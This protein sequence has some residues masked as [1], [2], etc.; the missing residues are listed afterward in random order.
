MK[1]KLNQKATLVLKPKRD[2]ALRNRH[3]WV[4]SGAVKDAP[5]AA[6]GDIV[7]VVS[8]EG[9]RLGYGH[10]MIGRD[11]CCRMLLFTHEAAQINE[12]FWRERFERALHHRRTFL[13]PEETS[14]YRLINAEGDSLPG[15]IVDV[16][17]D[18]AVIQARTE[19]MRRVLPLLVDFLS[20]ELQLQHIYDQ[21][22]AADTPSVWLKGN[23]PLV[24]FHED[25]VRYFAEPESG[26]KT[27]FFLDQ[28]DN[29]RLVG[30]LAPGRDVLNCFSYSGGF[31]AQALRHGARRAV[32]VDSSAAA[33]AL[34]DRV[35]QVNGLAERHTSVAADCFTYLTEL[36]PDAFDLIVL[37]P[38]AFAKHVRSVDRAA[39]GYKDINL[40]AMRRIRAG[41]ILFTYSCSQPVSSE[42]FRQIVFAAAADSGRSVRVIAQTGHAVDH[43][44]DL[45]HPEGNYLKGLVLV[46]D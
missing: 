11:I 16:Y 23:A 10:W 45:Y 13:R 46:V 9:E 3:P 29:R 31:S 28:R 17:A 37:D 33:L 22:E 5:D 25:D 30:R 41:G 35:M 7:Q 19:G 40:R 26:Q 6:E 21:R 42:L 36:E 4:F 15:L 34:A 2:R 14:G 32:S 38:P 18:A 43:P 8:A 39:R 12:A 27:G 20:R 24:E 1:A 44:V